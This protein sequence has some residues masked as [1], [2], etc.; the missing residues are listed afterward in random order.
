MIWLLARWL[1]DL[2]FP[3]LYR[4]RIVG[5]EH[6]P[7]TGP[8]I[9]AVNHVHWRDPPLAGWAVDQVRS[10]FFVG[11]AELFKNG[12]ARFVLTGL[13][14]IPLERGRGDVGALRKAEDLLTAGGCL[15]MFPE[16]TRSR[17]GVPGRPKPGVGFLAQ[18]TGAVVVPARVTGTLQTFG[19]MAI[20]FGKP[21][22]FETG[23]GPVTKQTYQAFAE[24]VMDSIL[25]L[26]A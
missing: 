11:K 9:V 2:L 20:R 1:T 13:H 21:M 8:L 7:V 25:K 24:S 10:P 17:T 23:E 6:V 15:I 22:R 16:G 3:T 18:R 5:L 26:E 14:S 4:A 12:L 19:P